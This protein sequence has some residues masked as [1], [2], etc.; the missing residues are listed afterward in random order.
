MMKTIQIRITAAGGRLAATYDLT[1]NRPTTI[2]YGSSVESGFELGTLRLP[3]RHRTTML[4]WPLLFLGYL[5]Q[6]CTSRIKTM[7]SEI[8][9]SEWF[10]LLQY[11]L[12][13]FPVSLI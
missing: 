9:V 4:Q 10:T 11:F 1:C 12:A 13:L 8:R 6:F 2:H 3:D 7:I 5:F